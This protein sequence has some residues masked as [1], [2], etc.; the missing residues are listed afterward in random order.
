MY[1]S[2]LSSVRKFP[3]QDAT[4]HGVRITSILDNGL[5]TSSRWFVPQMKCLDCTE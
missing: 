4:K 2:E 1:T 3:F 5:K